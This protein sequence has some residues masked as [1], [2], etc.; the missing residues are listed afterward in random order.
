MPD[1]NSDS[2]QPQGHILVNDGEYT[3][4]HFESQ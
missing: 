4:G 3:R 1:C 2:N